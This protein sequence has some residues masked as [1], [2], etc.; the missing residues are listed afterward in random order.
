M[1]KT[2]AMSARDRGV[3]ISDPEALTALL[4]DLQE[5]RLLLD[6]DL[7]ARALERQLG[8]VALLK[9]LVNAVPEG[10]ELLT[11]PLRDPELCPA[12]L[13]DGLRDGCRSPGRRSFPGSA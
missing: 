8:Q 5:H 13:R 7:L 12:A 6:E 10:D 1:A 4:G 2:V 9:T 3:D 11:S